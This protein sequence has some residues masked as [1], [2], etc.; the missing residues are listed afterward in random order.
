[1]SDDQ[2]RAAFEVAEEIRDPLDGLADKS[3]LDRAAPFRPEV[4]ERLAEP[5]QEDRG[6]F[7]A[8]RVALKA[9]GFNG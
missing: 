2:V 3:K 4:L 7:E 6:G 8:V 9:S 1:M 5:R